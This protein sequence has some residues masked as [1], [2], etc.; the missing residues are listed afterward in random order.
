MYKTRSVAYVTEVES[1]LI[2][3]FLGTPKCD[4]HTNSSGGYVSEGAMNYVYVTWKYF[5]LGGVPGRQTGS[6]ERQQ[7]FLDWVIGS[8]W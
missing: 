4:N 6:Q 5:E 7:S 3:A 1:R 8:G 2:R